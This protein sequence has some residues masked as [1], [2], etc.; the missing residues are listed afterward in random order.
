MKKLLMSVMAV[1]LAAGLAIAQNTGGDKGAD[2]HKNQP[3]APLVKT[4]AHK[5]GKKGHKGGKKGKK[6]S[7]ST[8]SK[9]GGPG[10]PPPTRPPSNPQ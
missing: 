8:D 2:T 3:A 1:L 5:G 9:P 7:V 10:K 4:K 6:S